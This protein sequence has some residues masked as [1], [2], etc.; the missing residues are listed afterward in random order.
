[1]PGARSTEDSILDTLGKHTNDDFGDTS[2]AADDFDTSED[3]G[4]ESTDGASGKAD[5]QSV[6]SDTGRGDRDGTKSD[7]N[8]PNGQR[9]G[10]KDDK[11]K[12]EDGKPRVDAKGNL[13]DQN[14][15][16]L[17]PAGA[18]RRVVQRQQAHIQNLERELTT[19]KQQS[20]DTRALDGVPARLG[21]DKDDVLTALQL[22]ADFNRNP[23]SIAKNIIERAL[24]MGHTLDDIIGK[25]ASSVE[26]GGIRQLI[27]TELA[28]IRQQRE[29]AA[30]VEKAQEDGKAAYDKF[31][32]D[33]PEAEPH[34]NDIAKL[35]GDRGWT[36]EQSLM[37]IMTFATQNGL[38]ISQPLGPQIKARVD[39]QNTQGNPGER[40]ANPQ[41]GRQPAP[42]GTGMNGGAS[43]RST[44]SVSPDESWD[45]VIRE[46]MRESGFKL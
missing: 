23:V 25:G 34:V 7:A 35:M 21:L 28:P 14:G 40:P 41:N 17:A 6:Q 43:V 39:A 8:T 19:L 4:G 1:M 5:S 22:A 38:D 29:Q 20:L 46:S 18:E 24:A 44:R 10:N 12:K 42:M 2:G 13:V 36:A 9:A 33:F 26:T 3:S 45:N 16:I 27:Q 32:A 31:M 37:R 15:N 11:S 30:K